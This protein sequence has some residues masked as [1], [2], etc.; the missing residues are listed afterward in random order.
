MTAKGMCCTRTIFPPKSALS[1]KIDERQNDEIGSY[2]KWFAVFYIR[3]SNIPLLLSPCV[4]PF[5]SPSLLLSP[6]A[7]CTFVCFISETINDG[8][9]VRCKR[10]HWGRSQD[11]WVPVCPSPCAM[12]NHRGVMVKHRHGARFLGLMTHSE[13]DLWRGVNEMN[14]RPD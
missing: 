12:M 7:S 14:K 9:C 13:I 8:L 11:P 4:Y 3:P 1:R 5:I 2:F 10:W 6:F